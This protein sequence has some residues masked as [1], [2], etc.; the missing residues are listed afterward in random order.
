[1]FVIYSIRLIGWPSI[2][3]SRSSMWMWTIHRSEPTAR[4]TRHRSGGKPATFPCRRG[5][6]VGNKRR[7]YSH[8]PRS[9]KSTMHPPSRL[10]FS[11]RRGMSVR[12][13]QPTNR[14]RSAN[15]CSRGFP[16][17]GIGHAGA[18]PIARG[19]ESRASQPSRASEPRQVY[20]AQSREYARQA[21]ADRP[22]VARSP[23]APELRSMCAVARAP[24]AY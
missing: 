23:I 3:M 22:R 19:I 14:P 20:R 16:D 10:G 8:C 15:T 18:H 7:H 1:M 13:F 21:S 2:V 4:R 5:D 11:T 24:S 6:P 17:L 9:A 12:P